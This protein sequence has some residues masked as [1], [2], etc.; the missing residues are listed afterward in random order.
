MVSCSEQDL[1]VINV[2]AIDVIVSHP[3]TLTNVSVDLLHY[4]ALA[5]FNTC[6]WRFSERERLNIDH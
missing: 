5:I 2:V 1:N 6:S 3:M 4:S